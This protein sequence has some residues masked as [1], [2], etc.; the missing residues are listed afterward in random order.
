MDHYLDMLL[1]N[2]SSD[3]DEEDTCRGRDGDVN[4]P[5][6]PCSEEPE[7][8]KKKRLKTCIEL[9]MNRGVT[10]AFVSGEE[11]DLD[12]MLMH[13]EKQEGILRFMTRDKDM[14][15]WG[16][17]MSDVHANPKR[18]TNL[19]FD[20]DDDDDDD[21]K[22]IPSRNF[23]SSDDGTVSVKHSGANGI[24]IEKRCIVISATNSTE[25]RTCSCH[26]RGKKKAVFACCTK[27]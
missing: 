27:I 12:Y 10:S 2:S 20:D 22:L 11:Q 13:D 23:F 15:V 17:C 18:R 7:K 5:F 26:E 19:N 1:R 9:I 6:S 21:N 16:L 25:D 8:R 14:D 24:S 4:S 3:E